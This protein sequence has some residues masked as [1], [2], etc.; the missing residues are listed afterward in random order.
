M[1]NFILSVF[2]V[3]LLISLISCSDDEDQLGCDSE[4]PCL[5]EGTSNFIACYKGGKVWSAANEPTFGLYGPPDA[6]S[7]SYKKEDETFAMRAIREIDADKMTFEVKFKNGDGLGTFSDLGVSRFNYLEDEASQCDLKEYY[8][9]P[10][11]PNQIELVDIGEKNN[12]VKGKFRLQFI[13]RD[14]GDFITLS[15]GVFRNNY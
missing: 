1:K 10:Q 15:Q 11:Y 13:G 3:S 4:L 12:Q 9:N 7:I 14:C 6:V 8:L 5:D 2:A